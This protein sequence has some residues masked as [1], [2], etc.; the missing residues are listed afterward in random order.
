MRLGEVQVVMAGAWGQWAD[1]S[2][3]VTVDADAGPIDLVAVDA[4]GCDPAE[5]G[6]PTRIVVPLILSD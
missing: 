1:F 5:C 2:T 6:E 3:T 4:S